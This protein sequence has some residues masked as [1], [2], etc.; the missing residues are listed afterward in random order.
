MKRFYLCLLTL[1]LA[2]GAA[3]AQGANV[4]PGWDAFVI[5]NA[6]V[7]GSPPNIVDRLDLGAGAV[8][9]QIYEG[10]QKAA[11]GT[12]LLNGA[13]VDQVGALHVDRLDNVSISGSL[14]GPYFNMWVT[15]GA[16]NY[17]VI[18]NEPSNA[19]WAADRWY[20]SGW[21][22]LQTTVCKVYETP[23][24]AG[25]TS[26]V[27]TYAGSPSLTFADVAGLIV[28]A[29]SAAY[30]LNPV[31]AVGSGAPREFGTN[32]AYG[33]NWMFGDTAANYVD[34]NGDGFVVGNYYV[35]VEY[36]VMN[37]TQSLGYFTI[38]AAVD[39]ANPGDDITVA[40]GHYVEQVHI[41]VD[42]LSITGAGVGLTFIDSPVVLPLSFTTSYVQKPIVFVDHADGVDIADLTIDGLGRGNSNNRF[43]GVSYW[44]S[45]G[46]LTNV[47]CLNVMDTPFSGTQHGVGVYTTVTDAT[48]HTFTM[49]D[50]LVDDFQKT[51]VVMT[52]SGL[53]AHLTGVTTVGQGPTSITAQNGIQVSGNALVFATGCDVSGV[54]YT[55]AS[56]TATGLLVYGPA[57]AHFD[58][59][60]VL[61]SQTGVYF[62]D[63][64][65][66]FD[67]STVAN[68]TGDAF[69]AYTSGAKAL[70]SGKLLPQPY[71]SEKMTSG[72]KVAASVSLTGSTFVGTG[73]ALSW[74]P[75]AYSDGPLSFTM[76]DCEVTNW[77]SG[78]VVYEYPGSSIDATVVNC[79]IHDNISYGLSTNA[80]T[81]VTAT[82]N[83]W[84]DDSGPNIVGNPSPGDNI[85]T[86]ATY[87][88]WL[89]A[90][91][92]ACVMYG[93]NNVSVGDAAL[94][95]TPTNT[96]VTIPV[97]FNRL[98]TTASRGVSVTFQLSPELVL[99][100]GVP[101]TSITMAT[102]VGSWS[103]GFSNLNHQIVDNG[104]GSYTV[105]RAVLGS[106]CGPTGG[107]VLFNLN[108][109]KAP[110]VLTDAIGTVTVTAVDVRDCSNVLL[111]GVPGAPGEVSIDLTNPPVLTGL[112][113]TQVKLGNDSDGT[114]KITL[115][116]TAPGGDAEFIDLWRKGF[117]DYPEYDDGTGAVPTAPPGAGW[118][119]VAQ[120]SATA[121]SYID[122]PATRDFWYYAAFVTD[123][124]GNVSAAS[125]LTGGTLNYHLGDVSDEI[126]AGSG[127]N[128]VSTAD[129]SLLGAHYGITVAHN[130]PFNYLDVGRT[131]DYSV[132]ARPMTDSRVQFEDLIVF[133]MNY[134][135]VSKLVPHAQPAAVNAIA[136]A[137]EM[138]GTV[139]TTFDVA[140][141]LAADGK[142]QGLSV[143]LTWDPAI[144]E[145]VS[146]RPGDL[147]QSQGELAVVLSPAP[148]TV[149]A[150]LM[151]VRDQGIAGEGVLA[152]VS[153][154][155]LAAG[156]PRIGIGNVTARDAANQPVVVNGAGNN[157]P[158][159]NLPSVSE[160]R[161]NVPNPFNPSTEFSFVL[162][163]DGPVTLRIYTV[164]GELVRT[165]VDQDMTAGP[166]VM[167]WNGTDDQGR[168][169][170]S[171]AYIARFVAPDRTQSRHLTLLK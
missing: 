63:A 38:Q 19:E 137:A 90:V 14:Y 76:D 117:G 129:I 50:V 128:L 118:T 103:S 53:T 8:E 116:W 162:A 154:R 138:P 93:D 9:F 23:G 157:L 33:F 91:N 123:G 39:A 161:P 51:G 169:A 57:T 69:Y 61:T 10:G 155:T 70:V 48:P 32:V 64:D 108:L 101:S 119:H 13:T 83:W 136:V 170:A 34:N 36:P 49:T 58:D 84:G 134:D 107:G 96:C 67:D 82:C 78:I 147:L 40:A 92:G 125:A 102:G 22:F 18:A 42:G 66:S 52:G 150:A 21:A 166:H 31:N 104:G 100:T 144:A 16:G 142:L 115:A 44:N 95:L 2:A 130:G 171:G 111:L 26:W 131:T 85:S 55:P 122:E 148:G 149:D 59:C 3:W 17:A 4:D 133:A 99:C 159:V 141:I 47:N 74:G 27:H 1:L 112:T 143:P 127:D 113:A 30:I 11:L 5:R 87:A 106:P 164:R 24:A 25:G 109:A 81:T 94:C 105:D 114:T 152:T 126:T 79:N 41:D 35:T 72:D 75:S 68:P 139:G 62:I 37:V 140:V 160:L 98:D 77:D 86:G 43:S 135:L 15:D 132:N 56:V 158:P 89:D 110:G 28:A 146:M 20:S 73:L 165:L 88:P 97:T 60:T 153:F 46:S 80:A 7:S 120:V 145:P 151:G 54:H 65:G 124:C 6:T 71:E 167:V 168:Q 156:D 12:N 45:G 29:P 163:Q 121:L